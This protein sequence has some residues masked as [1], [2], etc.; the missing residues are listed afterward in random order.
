MQSLF[1]IKDKEIMLDNAAST[2]PF[3]SVTEKINKALCSYGSVHR[4]FGPRSN[5]STELYEEPLAFFYL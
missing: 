4:G 3:K 5:A 2:P 1:N